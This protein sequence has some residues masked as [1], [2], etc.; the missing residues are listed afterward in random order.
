MNKSIEESNRTQAVYCTFI[1]KLDNIAEH[2]SVLH[3]FEGVR[4]ISEWFQECLNMEEISSIIFSPNNDFLKEAKKAKLFDVV[5]VIEGHF[6]CDEYVEGMYEDE[7]H[8]HNLLHKIINECLHKDELTTL[9]TDRVDV[10]RLVDMMSNLKDLISQE[11]TL[12]RKD[13]A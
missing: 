5:H 12:I 2:V 6:G 9:F 11:Q 1:Y 13:D 3:G 8:V 4:Y 10:K 7:F